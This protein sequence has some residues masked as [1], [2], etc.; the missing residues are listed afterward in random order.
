MD[1]EHNQLYRRAHLLRQ[2]E[3]S[4][5]HF[6]IAKILLGAFAERHTFFIWKVFSRSGNFEN[7]GFL[8]N[9]EILFP[10]FLMVFP[11]FPGAEGA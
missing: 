6:E 10:D 9:L 5:I 1:S 2:F 3:F 8:E 7:Q 11:D 4:E